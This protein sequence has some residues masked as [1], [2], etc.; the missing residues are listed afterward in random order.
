MD[1][2][3]KT[4]SDEIHQRC[5]AQ[6]DDSF[7]QV[8]LLVVEDQLKTALLLLRD[9]FAFDLLL[10]ITAVDYHPQLEPRFNVVYQVYSVSQNVNIELRVPVNHNHP[11]L[12]SITSI[13][14]NANWFEREI[15]D[16]FGIHF[17]GHP[18]LR[19]I[20]MPYDWQGHPLR[21]DYPLGYEEVQFTFNF[22]EINLRKPYAKE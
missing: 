12:P 18:D 5:G 9:T 1:E 3:L 7:E 22:D 4:V 13:Y 17:E 6:V 21:K 11:S 20:I 10:D 15:F 8:R 2:Y 19:R 16:M 14:I